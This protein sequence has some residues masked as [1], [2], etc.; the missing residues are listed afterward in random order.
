MPY[1]LLAHIKT[2][3]SGNIPLVRIQQDAELPYDVG[4][5]LLTMIYRYEEFVLETSTISQS[6][7]LFNVEWT[8]DQADSG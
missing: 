7:L 6:E 8:G 1:K 2:P 3:F 5:E 4:R